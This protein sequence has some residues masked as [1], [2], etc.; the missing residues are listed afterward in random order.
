MCGIWSSKRRCDFPFYPSL[1]GG[2]ALQGGVVFGK[3]PFHA[4]LVWEPCG[5]PLSVRGTR[6]LPTHC[7]CSPDALDYDF[8]HL[9]LQTQIVLGIVVNA[10]MGKSASTVD[11]PKKPQPA[12]NPHILKVAKIGRK[13]KGP[14]IEAITMT[15]AYPGDNRAICNLLVNQG[16]S[17]EPSFAF[18]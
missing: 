9:N 15:W 16:S 1:D 3:G 7:W 18:L 11:S 13:K 12:W 14:R 8:H 4:S 10:R 17:L 6:G 2:C 5:L